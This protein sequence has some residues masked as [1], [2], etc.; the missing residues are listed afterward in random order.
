[1]NGGSFVREVFL[2]VSMSFFVTEEFVNAI[3]GR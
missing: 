3:G 2:V 1:M